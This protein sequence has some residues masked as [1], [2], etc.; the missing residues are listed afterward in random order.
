MSASSL[1]LSK[2]TQLPI[3]AQ[4]RAYGVAG[5][6]CLWLVGVYI[7]LE[8]APTAYELMMLV[9]I[10]T[11]LIFP[12]AYKYIHD[13]LDIFEPLV[14]ANLALASMFLGRPIFDLNTNTWLHE[15]F[16][17]FFDARPGFDAMLLY[18]LLGIVALQI[19]Y[20][21]SVPQKIAR[22]MPVYRSDMNASRMVVI[23][24]VMFL[25]GA[26]LFEEYIRQSGGIKFLVQY[27]TSRALG[28][29]FSFKAASGYL[30]IGPLFWPPAAM[31]AL[32]A[33]F[34]TRKVSYLF[35]TCFFL[36]CFFITM[37]GGVGRTFTIQGL[38]G[39]VTIGYVGRNKRPSVLLVVPVAFAMLL[40]FVY[41]RD[42]RLTTS[43][44]GKELV[45]E[46]IVAHPVDALETIWSED[47]AAMADYFSVIVA[48]VPERVG[49]GTGTTITDVLLRAYPRFLAPGNKKPDEHTVYVFKKFFPAVYYRYSAGAAPSLIGEL[50]ADHGGIA[51]ALYMFFF[52]VILGVPKEWM[53]LSDRAIPSQLLF[54]AMPA[55][56]VSLMRGGVP[57]FVEYLAITALPIVLITMCAQSRPSRA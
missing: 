35:L 32:S 33:W 3:P 46:Q 37:L 16:A 57:A 50:Y 22:K 1:T 43:F 24:W 45:V 15:W 42:A 19:G 56:T 5:F 26:T 28:S 2:P 36:T 44:A 30:F 12:P 51:I 54:V 27:L 18:A 31:I 6:A 34:Q 29:G 40:F 14:F 53:R 25:I 41:D 7:L 38:L 4:S 21:S 11:A 20:M 39:V 17:T 10:L 48:N 9:S 52:G 8:V 13:D 47:D 49:Y 55:Y 23:A